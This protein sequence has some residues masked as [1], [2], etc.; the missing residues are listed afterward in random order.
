M[1]H[2]KGICKNQTPIRSCII[3]DLYIQLLSQMS[4]KIGFILLHIGKPHALGGVR[5]ARVGECAVA[6]SGNH[7]SR[8]RLYNIYIDLIRI[9]A[10]A[11]LEADPPAAAQLEAAGPQHACSSLVIF[12]AV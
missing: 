12:P 9:F 10:A 8:I 2:V 11:K 3:D 1:V 6:V 5:E 7:L 4:G